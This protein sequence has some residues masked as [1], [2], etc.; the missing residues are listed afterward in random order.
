MHVCDGSDAENKALLTSLVAAGAIE[1]VPKRPGCYLARTDPGDVAR[2]VDRTFICSEKE[3][4]SGPT[5]KHQEPTQMMAKLRGLFDSVMTG[6]T[7][8]VIPYSMGPVGSPLARYGVQ[9]TDSA[10]VVANMRIMTRIGADVLEAIGTDEKSMWIPS[11]HT[12]GAPLAPG[13]KDVAWPCNKEKYICHFPDMPVPEI[14]SYGSG[15]GGNSLLGKKCFALRIASVL[16][17]RQGWLAEHMLVRTMSGEREEGE[18]NKVIER[19]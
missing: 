2:V 1:T 19:K 18:S 9:I 13:Q 3:S 7:M 14:W 12:V 6:R 11:L 4:D 16:A 5:N 15:Y 10:F 17:K 8:Y